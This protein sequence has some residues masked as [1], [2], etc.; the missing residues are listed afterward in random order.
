MTVQF[1][2]DRG[3]NQLPEEGRKIDE[4]KARNPAYKD[5]DEAV[6]TEK[7][8]QKFPQYQQQM[9]QEQFMERMGVVPRMRGVGDGVMKG[10]K[11][12]RFSL[13]NAGED[14]GR[15]ERFSRGMA[16]GMVLAGEGAVQSVSGL[17]GDDESVRKSGDIISNTRDA[18]DDLGTSGQVGRF[19]GEV[20]PVAAATAPI[21]PSSFVAGGAASGGIEGFTRADATGEKGTEDRLKDAALNSVLGGLFGGVVKGLGVG[22]KALGKGVAAA[23]G[24]IDQKAAL[25]LAEQGI[26]VSAV[27]AGSEW[28]KGYTRKFLGQSAFG[29]SRVREAGERVQGQIEKS[30]DNVF[31]QAG[32]T[33]STIVEAGQKIIDTLDEAKVGLNEAADVLSRGW[34]KKA[35]MN[36]I[37]GEDDLKSLKKVFREE[38][39][40]LA[41]TGVDEVIRKAGLEG[42]ERIEDIFTSLEA[43]AKNKQLTVGGL[44]EAK[45]KIGKLIIDTPFQT[46]KGVATNRLFGAVS[47]DLKAVIGKESPEALEEFKKFNNFYNKE[48]TKLVNL[49]KKYGGGKTPEQAFNAAFS[50]RNLGIDNLKGIIEKM[51]PEA[52]DALRGDILRKM[53]IKGGASDLGEVNIGTFVNNYK[54]LSPEAKRVIL[55]TEGGVQNADKLVRNYERVKPFIDA[56]PETG[57]QTGASLSDVTAAVAML[58]GSVNPAF[59]IG[60]ALKFGSDALFSR[61]W[62]NPRTIKLVSNALEKG[63]PEAVRSAAAAMSKIGNEGDKTRLKRL[64]D[65]P[66]VQR[67]AHEAGLSKTKGKGK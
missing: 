11:A 33:N 56:V 37:V 44:Y 7:L 15:V 38:R 5:V 57:F 4:F 30:L 65:M 54:K 53:S 32:N 31:K 9:T 66:S 36:K 3:K 29:K 18:V 23:A 19:V 13:L 61:L 41:G 52:A 17:M 42:A 59:A 10:E 21:F 28:V 58:G 27:T 51:K 49:T 34:Q 1:V 6:L 14:A 35:P 26:D 25:E 45:K 48:K 2:D 39:S 24:K 8:Y 43:A 47:E 12:D 62:T 50:A 64:L 46:E 16:G 63:T 40:A 22:G 60:A 55:K 67:S 20:A